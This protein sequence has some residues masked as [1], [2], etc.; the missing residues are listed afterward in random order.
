LDYVEIEE[1]A[2]E[3]ETSNDF[4]KSESETSDM[5]ANSEKSR[6][7]S[8]RSLLYFFEIENL[9]ALIED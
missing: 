5:A 2:E 7:R 8:S 4:N 9:N 3:Q 1:A 6:R